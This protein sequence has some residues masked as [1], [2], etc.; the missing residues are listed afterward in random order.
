MRRWL[1]KPNHTRRKPK[2]N[3]T[4]NLVFLVLFV[5]FLLLRGWI[6]RRRR[7]R[8]NGEVEGGHGRRLLGPLHPLPSHPRRRRP[9]HPRRRP[10]PP[11]L[12]FLPR[13][14]PTAALLLPQCFPSRPRA[15]LLAFR[16]RLLRHPVSPRRLRH[17]QLV[18][19]LCDSFVCNPPTPVCSMLFSFPF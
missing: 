14:P 1:P 10:P 19:G 3:P 9:L 7:R 11:H 2:P 17:L 8:K 16:D 4:Q 12:P 5:S 15:F 6:R 18:R 13:P